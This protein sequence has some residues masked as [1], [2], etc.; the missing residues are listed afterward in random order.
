MRLVAVEPVE[1]RHPVHVGILAGEDGG[2]ARGADGIHRE[3]PVQTKALATDAIQIRGLVDDAAVR[4]DGVGGVVVRHD[5]QDVGPPGGRG[6]L[7]DCAG[8]ED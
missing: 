7:A 2:A 3:T 5:E 4:T 8:D 6:G 1:H